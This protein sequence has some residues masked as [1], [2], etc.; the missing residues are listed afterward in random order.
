MEIKTWLFPLRDGR[1]FRLAGHHVGRDDH[2]RHIPDEVLDSVFL[3][4]SMLWVLLAMHLREGIGGLFFGVTIVRTDGR[5]ASRLR[6]AWREAL[7]WAPAIAI[8]TPPGDP[9]RS[10]AGSARSA[11]TARPASSSSCRSVYVVPA[12]FLR[13]RYLNDLLAGT[14]VVPK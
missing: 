8:D 10:A 9:S 7:R 14:A 12:L 3:F 1:L 4:Q 5:R 6:L 13:G 2:Q 11:S